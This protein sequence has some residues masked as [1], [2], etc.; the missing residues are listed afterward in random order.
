MDVV[1]RR[2]Q[3]ERLYLDLVSIGFVLVVEYNFEQPPA[4]CAAITVAFVTAC[5]GDAGDQTNICPLDV[6]DFLGV[7]EKYSTVTTEYGSGWSHF[8][9]ASFVVQAGSKRSDG[10]VWQPVPSQEEILRRFRRQ[11]RKVLQ[12]R[13]LGLLSK[14][15]AAARRRAGTAHLKQQEAYFGFYSI[16]SEGFAADDGDS[17]CGSGPYSKRP[18]CAVGGT[19]ARKH[20]RADDG[21]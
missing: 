8:D 13:Q 18:G 10:A 21:E 2:A 17:V 15:E 12:Q 1:S 7:R 9:I 4:A 6:L 11:L 14:L 19:A 5:L 16:I 20:R 3:S